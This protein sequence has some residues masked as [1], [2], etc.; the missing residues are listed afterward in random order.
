MSQN[1][2]QLQHFEAWEKRKCE[3]EDYRS[4]KNIEI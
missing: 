4:E 2:D 1:E 3:K